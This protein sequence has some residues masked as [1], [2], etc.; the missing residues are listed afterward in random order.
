M[1]FAKSIFVT[2]MKTEAK[3]LVPSPV[4]AKALREKAV[5]GK[6][7][8]VAD[9]IQVIL[10]DNA[11]DYTGPGTN[12]YLVGEDRLWVIDPGPNDAV[13]L[14]AVIDAVDGREVEGILVTHNHLDHSPAAAPLS[15]KLDAPVYGYGGLPE[16]I[17]HASDEDIDPDFVPNHALMGGEK[18]G[19]GRW[20][21]Q[22]IHTPGH[23]PN[24]LC[25]WLPEVGILFTGDHVMGWSTTV[26]VPPL[27]NLPD[28]M[29]SLD[30]LAATGAVRLMPS[31]G[32][33]VDNAQSRISEV[34]AH[35]MMRQAQVEECLHQGMQCPKSIVSELYEGLT[36][37]LL[38]AAEGCVQ[39]HIDMYHSRRS[40]AERFELATG[41]PAHQ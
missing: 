34:R 36:P 10:A 41:N 28:Y 11:K 39:A 31:H 5:Y 4:A 35:R 19:S 3:G 13:H 29:D 1:K 14:N 17:L 22:V 20:R 8:E 12:T 9:G 7:I 26:I 38:Q 32:D 21:L 24:H 37:R 23:F 15:E 40:Q 27:G 33:P 18:I 25:Y 6:P 16:E 30:L 2:D